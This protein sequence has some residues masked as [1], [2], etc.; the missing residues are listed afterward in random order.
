MPNRFPLIVFDWDGTLMDSTTT[1]ATSIQRACAD[2]ELEVPSDAAAS[3]VIGMGLSD[4]LAYAVPD[5]TTE[6]L[7]RM[8]E[9]YRHHYLSRDADLRLF[10]G[11]AQLLAQLRAAGHQLAVATGKSRIG[12]ERS[13]EQSGVRG[14]FA[15]SRT[16]DETNPKPDPA[17]L[18]ELSD[19][20]EVELADTL[21]IGDTSH[22]LQMAQNARAAGLGVCYGAHPRAELIACRPLAVVDSVAQLRDWLF[23][24]A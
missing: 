14:L 22:D 6:M 1:I 3:H 4:A 2:L 24:N 19:E 17:M 23:T 11:V 15:A 9:R 10:A 20:L 21:M 18:I 7:P 16:A 13:F 12:L 8:L 5:L